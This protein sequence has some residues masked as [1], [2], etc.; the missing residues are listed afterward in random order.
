MK[1]EEMRQSEENRPPSPPPS[2]DDLF[3]KPV[4]LVRIFRAAAWLTARKTPTDGDD[5]KASGGRALHI[6]LG[7]RVSFPDSEGRER[8]SV[9]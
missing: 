6:A 1:E 8:K 7:C 5:I 4:P 2:D 9:Q 3:F